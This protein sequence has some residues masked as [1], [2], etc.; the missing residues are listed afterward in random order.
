MKN[1]DIFILILALIF[2]L[3]WFKNYIGLMAMIYYMQ[4]R[5]YKEPSDQEMEECIK[6]AI[7]HMAQNLF[8]KF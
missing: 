2:A 7:K 1:I 4:F 8:N 6:F 3:G 5:N